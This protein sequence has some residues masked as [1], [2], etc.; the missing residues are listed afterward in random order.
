MTRPS[1]TPTSIPTTH[2]P[3]PPRNRLAS[4]PSLSRQPSHL[5]H[6]PS[7]DV[8]GA[9]AEP[10]FLVLDGK[11]GIATVG[12][13]WPADAAEV[14]LPTVLMGDLIGPFCA[15]PGGGL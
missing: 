10:A 14:N 2:Y 12:L 9:I 6:P 11:T 1:S 13:V 15:S 5:L 7:L 3:L 4:L 8:L